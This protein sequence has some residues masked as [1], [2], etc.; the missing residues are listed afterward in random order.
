MMRSSS[1]SGNAFLLS[2]EASLRMQQE[3]DL[4]SSTRSSSTASTFNSSCRSVTFG[5][6][7]VREFNRIAGDH[8]DCAE[9]P[10]MSIDWSFAELEPVSVDKHQTTRQGSFTVA[11]IPSTL[12]KE[13]LQ[14]GFHVPPQDIKAAEKMATKAARQREQTIQR[15]LLTRRTRR[16]CGKF[17]RGVARSVRRR[18]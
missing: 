7:Q 16:M 4:L 9:G 3:E 10:P 8:P 15:H 17:F 11:P 1:L 6:V 5:S 14:F 2:K 18:R 12:R 13:I